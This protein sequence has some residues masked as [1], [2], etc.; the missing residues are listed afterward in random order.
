M[1][2]I[3]CTVAP[4]AVTLALEEML[5]EAAVIVEEPRAVA[6]A[7]PKVEFALIA[8]AE[9]LA[10]VHCTEAVISFVLPSVKVPKAVSCTVVPSGNDP[11]DGETVSAASAAAVTVRVVLPPTPEW[12]AVIVADPCALVAAM[13]VL[14]MVAAAVFDEV[15]VAEFVRSL[16][17]LSLY[18]PVALNCCATP[19]AID[20]APGVIWIDCNTAGAGALLDDEPPPPQPAITRTITTTHI[21]AD[22]IWN[23][24]MR[25]FLW[26]LW[27]QKTEPKVPPQIF[28]AGERAIALQWG[29]EF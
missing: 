19:A 6:I 4:V 20:A 13:P 16:L 22:E 26:L 9:G 28:V 24:F 1:I 14:E 21:S 3:D 2:A 27:V 18:R 10:D 7:R 8:T 29:I 23:F 11:V 12:L 15:Q 17:L 25:F 5:P